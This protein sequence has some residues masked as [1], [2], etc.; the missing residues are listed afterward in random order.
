MAD[1][2][3]AHGLGQVPGVTHGSRGATTA[4]LAH[5][6]T[7]SL[8]PAQRDAILTFF[9]RP[10]KPADV[11]AAHKRWADLAWNTRVELEHKTAQ[12]QQRLAREI[13]RSWRELLA[14]YVLW[15]DQG[16]RQAALGRFFSEWDAFLRDY[17]TRW[18]QRGSAKDALRA[19]LAAL[20]QDQPIPR[21]TALETQRQMASY[22]D[23]T[24]QMIAGSQ[25]RET[26]IRALAVAYTDENTV[27]AILNDLADGIAAILRS[28][29]ASLEMILQLLLRAATRGI[30]WWGWVIGAGALLIIARPYVGVA[31]R[32]LPKRRASTNGLDGLGG[33]LGGA[34][35]Y[36]LW[37]QPKGKSDPLYAQVLSTQAKSMQDVEKVKKVASRDGWHS[38]R[39]QILDLSE[40]FDASA[41]FT[42]AVRRRR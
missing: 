8:P 18:D 19:H 24:L 30:P 40:P 21:E 16:S 39:V 17:R 36:I 20:P 12:A 1:V 26:Q 25:Q 27:A 28:A 41:A 14:A 7:M 11:L 2:I 29:F 35:E 31:A 22:A 4:D 5:R 37:G 32:L 3:G 6:I 13:G 34:K 9:S 15:S 33:G 10:R 38:F 23:I 42:K